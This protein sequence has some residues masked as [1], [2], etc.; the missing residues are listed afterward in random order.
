MVLFAS[1][2]RKSENSVISSAK[3]FMNL[4]MPVREGEGCACPLMPH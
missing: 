4:S 1:A 3:S 2:F